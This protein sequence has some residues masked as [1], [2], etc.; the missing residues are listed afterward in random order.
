MLLAGLKLRL[1]FDGVSLGVV[2]VLAILAFRAPNAKLHCLIKIELSLNHCAAA[3]DLVNLRHPD[4]FSQDSHG[5][6]P[7]RDAKLAILTS[8]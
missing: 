7:R 8:T 4:Q 5:I 1:N 6:A 2:A 3:F